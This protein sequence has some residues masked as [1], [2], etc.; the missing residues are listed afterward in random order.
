MA[1]LIECKSCGR[2]VRRTSIVCTNPECGR[3]PHVEPS[4]VSTAEPGARGGD[5]PHSEAA[6]TPGPTPAAEQPRRV[7]ITLP[8]HDKIELGPGERVVLGRKSSDERVVRAFPE[9][10]DDVSRTHVRV[11]NDP[12]GVALVMLGESGGEVGGTFIEDRRLPNDEGERVP[13]RH[14]DRFRL[15]MHAWCKVEVLGS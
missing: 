1:D 2:P 4:E 5:E 7:T 13:L 6:A 14:G 15:G 10:Y 12:T 8:N 9:Q 3:N 11:V